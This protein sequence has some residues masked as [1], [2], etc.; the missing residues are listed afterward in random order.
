MLLLAVFSERFAMIAEEDDQGVVVEAVWGFLEPRKE[1]AEL[2]VR[3]RDFTFVQLLRV[4]R[5]ER[6][7]RV[8]RTVRIVKV[9]PEEK[10]LIRM[11]F[12]PSNGVIH[13]LLGAAFHEAKVPLQKFL[14]GKSIIVAVKAAGKPPASIQD[15]R[16]D[17]SAGGVTIGPQAFSQGSKTIVQRLCGEIPD[18]IMKGIGAGEDRRVRWQG[19]GDLRDSAFEYDGI[20]RESVYAWRETAGIAIAAHAVSA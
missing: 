18:A 15:E 14:P 12:Q 16:T 7:R 10:R 19:K 1:P 11:R 13:A 8:I 6:L 9:K 2:A 4:L 20:F 5:A 3:I 17:D